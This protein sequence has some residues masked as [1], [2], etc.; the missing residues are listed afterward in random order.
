[1]T[2]KAGVG[3]QTERERE[4]Q[5]ERE[6]ERERERKQANKEADD[7]YGQLGSSPSGPLWEL[8]RIYLRILPPKDGV[9]THQLPSAGCWLPL[10]HHL[11]VLTAL[12]FELRGLAS[13]DTLR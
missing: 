4:G 7:C 3:K 10:G 2:L 12:A 6:K 11:H 8:W 5:R 1:M 13:E 9:F